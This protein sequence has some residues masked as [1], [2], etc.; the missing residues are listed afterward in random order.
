[1]E[2]QRGGS[3]AGG[4]RLRQKHSSGKRGGSSGSQWGGGHFCPQGTYNNVWRLGGCHSMW[5]ERDA[6]Q[7]PATH[8]KSPHNNGLPGPSV[9]SPGLKSPSL[10]WDLEDTGWKKGPQS[11]DTAK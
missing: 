9:G 2:G 10:D 1:M 6:A 8:K 5:V 11:T 4:E 7:P 3:R